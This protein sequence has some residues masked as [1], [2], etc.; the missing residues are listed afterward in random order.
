MGVEKFRKEFMPQEGIPFFVWYIG[1]FRLRY[2]EAA[3]V[4]PQAQQPRWDS[5][6]VTRII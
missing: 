2:N 6:T 3:V 5:G 4:V 1:T